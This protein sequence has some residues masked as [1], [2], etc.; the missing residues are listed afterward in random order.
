[1]MVAESGE[2]LRPIAGQQ[3]QALFI[4]QVLEFRRMRETMFAK[5][6]FAD[7]A[8]DMLLDLTAA[9][10]SARAATVPSAPARRRVP[11]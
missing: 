11:S 9:A 10:H 1:M 3:A 5:A 6:L 7:P 4:R 2:R 8:W